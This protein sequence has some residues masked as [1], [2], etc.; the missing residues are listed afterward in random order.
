MIIAPKYF[1]T[2]LQGLNITIQVGQSDVS[3]SSSVRDLGATLDK[4]M[5]MGPQVSTVVRSMYA[6]IRMIGKIHHLLPQDTCVTVTN[7][8]VSSRLDYRN[9]LLANVPKST[10]Q[11][12]QMAQNAAARQVTGARRDEHM[13]PILKALHWL[14][15][16]KCKVYKV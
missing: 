10:L 5:N 9:G 8:L 11:S 4:Y 13:T 15:V 1:H 14:P 3:P 6:N 2:R 12:L 7:S 16:H